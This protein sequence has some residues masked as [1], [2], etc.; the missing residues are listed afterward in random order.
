MTNPVEVLR[1]L[2]RLN[3]GVV[4]SETGERRPVILVMENGHRY[5]DG[6]AFQEVIN[7]IQ[8]GRVNRHYLIVLSPIIKI[9][10]EMEA[11]KLFNVIEHELPDRA[12][13]L[14]IASRVAAEEE[15]PTG[16]DLEKMLEA[17]AGMPHMEF[18]GA[19]A[20][21]LVRHQ[22]LVADE[23]FSIKRNMLKT[24]QALQLH[25]GGERFADVGGLDFMKTYS[26][27]LLG[28][29]EPNPKFRSKGMLI[30]GVSGG[31][32]SLFAKALGNEVG[33]PTLHF[34][35]GA[36]MGSLLGQ[37]QNAFRQALKTADAMAP[38]I[39]FIDEVEKALAGAGKD[40]ATSGGVKTEIFGTFLSWLQDHES[41]VFVVCTANDITK[42]TNDNPEF[43]RRFDS[44]FFVDFPGRAAKDQ[45]WRIHLRGYEL[46]AL[47][48]LETMLE[49]VRLA[50]H[51][52]GRG[53]DDEWTGAE[54]ETCCRQA[55]QRKLSVIEVGTQLPRLIDQAYDTIRLTREWAQGKAYA[56]EYE[57][58]YIPQEHEQRISALAGNGDLR[59]KVAKPRTR[60]N[61]YESN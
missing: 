48:N 46:A 53:L 11:M 50:K 52:S 18:E 8:N 7:L 47:D 9:P 41:D 2:P 24:Q 54:I 19:C 45:I 22:K 30:T 35:I 21:S 15:M 6:G 25:R 12:Q 29:I 56:A 5:L 16:L 60:P 27:Q 23:I 34:N 26:R 61:T 55:R 36:C 33:R 57:G 28:T 43:I 17:G 39:L 20:L 44:L 13:R 14:D 40:A 51:R 49:A 4:D 58:I 42:V 38:C 3:E 37:S 59:R 10:A 31:G 32:K 1:E